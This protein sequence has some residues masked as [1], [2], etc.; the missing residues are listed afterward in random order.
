MMVSAADGNAKCDLACRA[1]GAAG[2]VVVGGA[3]VVEREC[4]TGWKREP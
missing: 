2:A 3:A 4:P 1:S